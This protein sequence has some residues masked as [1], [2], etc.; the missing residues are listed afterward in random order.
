MGETDKIVKVGNTAFISG[1]EPSKNGSNAILKEVKILEATGTSTSDP[2]NPDQ[3][4]NPDNP[5][6]PDN[7][8]NPDQPGNPEE[9]GGSKNPDQPDN[10]DNPGESTDP[11]EPE[12]PGDSENS[13]KPNENPD[14]ETPQDNS[15]NNQPTV[16]VDHDKSAKGKN[17][18]S[19]PKTSD[20]ALLFRLT[21]LGILVAAIAFGITMRK[22]HNR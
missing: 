5:D 17:A 2:D 8:D 12:N 18:L 19:F 22:R 7:P 6:Q 15:R 21:I 4:D 16:S 14:S 3:P 9:P 11:N 1:H 10:P 13:N 20:D